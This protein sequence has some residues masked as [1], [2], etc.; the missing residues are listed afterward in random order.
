MVTVPASTC[1]LQRLIGAEQ[2]LL[3]GLSARVERARNLGAAEGAVGQ[4]AA[5]FAREGNALRHALVDDVDADLRQPV[6]VGFARAEVAALH[7][8]VE[9]AVDAVAVVLIIFRGVDAALRGDGVRAPRRILEAEALDVVAELAERRGAADPPASPEPT[10]MMVYLR[11]FA[12]FTSF[13]SKRRL[14]QAFRWG[15]WEIWESSFAEGH[16]STSRSNCIR[17]MT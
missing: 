16:L 8:V 12:G 3:A 5:V 2:K 17:Y 4:H 9:Q 7:R 1:A 11:L 13:I 15:R 14:S 10:T 6:D